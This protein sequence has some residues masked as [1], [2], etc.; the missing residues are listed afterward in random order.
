MRNLTDLYQE[1]MERH[2]SA[3]TLVLILEKLQHEGMHSH[4]VKACLKALECYPG[5][6]RIQGMLAEAYLNMGFI[7]QA[8]AQLGEVTAAID[9][10]AVAYKQQALLCA[11][12][13]RTGEAVRHLRRYLVHH[14]QDGDAL[15][16]LAG[17]TGEPAL[18]DEEVDEELASPTLAEIYVA[19]GRIQEAVETYEKVVRKNQDDTDSRERLMELKSMEDRH[20]VPSLSPERGPKDSKQRMI[21][22]LEAWLVNIRES[23]A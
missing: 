9:E 18:L 2:P 12:Q 23:N 1:I 16:L 14:P 22:I 19:Q 21:D 13:R 8:E 5:D 10:L 6:L 3:E 11:R 4:T 7:G 20:H 17:W 15:T